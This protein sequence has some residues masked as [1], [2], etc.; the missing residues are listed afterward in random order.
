MIKQIPTFV[1]KESVDRMLEDVK[2]IRTMSADNGYEVQNAITA[3]VKSEKLI[4]MNA[5]DNRATL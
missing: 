1:L 3:V 2:K 5:K 4:E